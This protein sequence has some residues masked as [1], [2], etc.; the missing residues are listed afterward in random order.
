M[1]SNKI[2]SIQVSESDL[3]Y[4]ESVLA[5]EK[6]RLGTFTEDLKKADYDKQIRTK[7]AEVKNLE[8]SRERLHLEMAELNQQSETRARLGLKRNELKKKEDAVQNTY[9]AFGDQDVDKALTVAFPPQ[10]RPECGQIPA[11]Y[12]LHQRSS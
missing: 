7:Q 6:E 4:H 1:W 2:E 12:A 8:E 9:V 11:I 3:K 5:E 10:Y